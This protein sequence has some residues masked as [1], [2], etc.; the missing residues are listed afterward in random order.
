M[1]IKYVLNLSTVLHLKIKITG[2][3]RKCS[4]AWLKCTENAH[5][6]QFN[7]NKPVLLRKRNTEA[8]VFFNISTYF[9]RSYMHGY[10]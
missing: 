4:K 1:L 10:F 6:W 3:H 8:C 7:I 9:F 2:M 5:Q